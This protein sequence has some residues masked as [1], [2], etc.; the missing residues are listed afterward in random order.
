MKNKEKSGD[1]DEYFTCLKELVEV[2]F[3]ESLEV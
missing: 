1:K 2:S 3:S